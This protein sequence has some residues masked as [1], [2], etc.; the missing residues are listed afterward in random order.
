MR[1]VTI[2]RYNQIMLRYSVTLVSVDGEYVN[3]MQGGGESLVLEVPEGT[4]TIVLKCP[5][6]SGVDVQI[7]QSGDVY[8]SYGFIRKGTSTLLD[9][10]MTS[11][12][13]FTGLHKEAITDI[14]SDNVGN[15]ILFSILGGIAAG[16]FAVGIVLLNYNTGLM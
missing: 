13:A 5:G 14:N 1:K 12:K 15:T 10:T 16:A 2:E 4:S 9:Y 7:P 6:V 8:L 3:K 11:D